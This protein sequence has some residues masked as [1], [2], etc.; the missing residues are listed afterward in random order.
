MTP[1]ATISVKVVPRA[2]RDEIVGWLDG[3]LKV[4]VAAPPTDGKANAAVEALL[5][6]A[7]ELPRKS[8]RVVVGHGAPR[9]RI[10]IDGVA[11]DEV[12]RRLRLRAAP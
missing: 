10:E 5:A 4:R 6:A 9:K 3:A 8:V 12:E 11:R 2:S 7:L 1:K